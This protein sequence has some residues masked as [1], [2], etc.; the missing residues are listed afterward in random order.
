MDE[1]TAGGGDVDGKDRGGVAVRKMEMER[2]R[3]AG[4]GW[5]HAHGLV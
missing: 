5:G 1:L 3:G 4:D 2:E